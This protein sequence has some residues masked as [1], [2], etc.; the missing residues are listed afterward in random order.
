[1]LPKLCLNISKFELKQYCALN[2]VY[3][4]AKKPYEMTH[5]GFDHVEYTEIVTFTVPTITLRIRPIDH[6]FYQGFC[7]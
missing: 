4:F 3:I 6:V 1:M 7:H 2:D 5:F